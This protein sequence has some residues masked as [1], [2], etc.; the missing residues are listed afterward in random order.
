MIP[1]NSSSSKKGEARFLFKHKSATTFSIASSKDDIDLFTLVM[2]SDGTEGMIESDGKVDA[3]I[4]TEGED[5]AL[6]LRRGKAVDPKS[7][8]PKVGVLQYLEEGKLIFKVFEDTAKY[9][10][11]LKVIFND[12][13]S[14][15]SVEKEDVSVVKFVSNQGPVG[16]SGGTARISSGELRSYILS[17]TAIIYIAQTSFR[18]K[19]PMIKYKDSGQTDSKS[20]KH[21]LIRKVTTDKKDR[22]EKKDL[23]KKDTSEK[24][25]PVIRKSTR[26][27]KKDTIDRKDTQSRETESPEKKEPVIRKSTRDRKKDTIDRKDTQSRETESPEKKSPEKKEPIARKSTREKRKDT[28]DRKDTQSRETESPEKKSPEKKD[29]LERKETKDKKKE[30]VERKKHQRQERTDN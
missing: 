30:P 8:L 13:G 28:I 23:D 25:E 26:D 12:D 7:P 14:K 20:E 1:L 21:N 22:S 17:L 10:P 18:K 9:G 6:Y 15:F 2:E 29:P 5:I 19:E 3:K 24:K 4:Q 16:T 11:D 27:R